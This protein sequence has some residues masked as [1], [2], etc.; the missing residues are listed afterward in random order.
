MKPTILIA[1]DSAELRRSLKL[2][3]EAEGYEVRVASNGAEAMALQQEAPADVL[4]AD[5]FMPEADGFEAIEGFRRTFPKTRIVAMSGNAQRV[6][7]EFLSVAALLGVDATLKKPF[8]MDALLKTL[9][10]LQRPTT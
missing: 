2:G 1:E 5:L 7:R 9:N 3:L 10:D 6:K 8:G 4:I